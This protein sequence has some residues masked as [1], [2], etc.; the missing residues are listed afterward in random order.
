VAPRAALTGAT[1]KAKK[2]RR[3]APASLYFIDFDRD[4]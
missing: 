2:S 4:Y 1:V 3:G